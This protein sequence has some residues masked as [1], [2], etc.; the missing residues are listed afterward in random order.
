MKKDNDQ[1]VDSTIT[2]SLT[3]FEQTRLAQKMNAHY[4]QLI[5]DTQL[6]V[7]GLEKL[8]AADPSILTKLESLADET[9]IALATEM[10]KVHGVSA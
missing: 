7:Q 5:I 8:Q 6:L 2:R 3:P 1:N 10:E 9:L 4:M